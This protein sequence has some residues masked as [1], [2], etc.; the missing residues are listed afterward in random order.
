MR[1]RIGD[2]IIEC[3]WEMSSVSNRRLTALWSP[4]AVPYMETNENTEIQI[5]VNALKCKYT[6]TN[7]LATQCSLRLIQVRPT[8][9]LWVRDH[10]IKLR[11]G[12]DAPRYH[13]KSSQF[14][15][16]SLS[17]AG[18]SCNCGD[19][20]E[21]L[22]LIG[23][24]TCGMTALK[25]DEKHC[26]CCGIGILCRGMELQNERALHPVLKGMGM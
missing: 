5:T 4:V 12:C 15:S 3:A 9:V 23:L 19:Q 7:D 11:T 24:V 10:A 18:V 1:D 14:S 2:D 21:A 6:D 17:H 16:C 8:F 26:G 25:T 20:A 13:V 22:A